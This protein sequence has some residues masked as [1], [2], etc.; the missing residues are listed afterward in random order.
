[1]HLSDPLVEF[2]KPFLASLGAVD[3]AR[4]LVGATG[5]PSCDKEG[6]SG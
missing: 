2:E 3:C 6:Y 4:Y 5:L 1:M